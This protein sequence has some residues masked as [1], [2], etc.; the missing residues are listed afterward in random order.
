MTTQIKKRQIFE[1]EQDLLDFGRAYL[2]EAFPNP[3]RKG[4]PPEEMLR[5]LARRPTQSDPSITDH[6]T[7]CSPCFNAYMAHLDH[8][9]AEAKESSRMR[10]AVWFKWSAV[11][12]GIGVLFVIASYLLFMKP[13][14]TPS[15][16]QRPPAPVGKPGIPAQIP[17]TGKYIPVLVDLSTAA[18]GR[19]TND[20]RPVRAKQTVPANQFVDLSLHLPVGSDAAIYSIQIRSKRHTE[21]TDSGRA[22]LENGQP[23]LRMHADFSHIHPGKYDLLVVSKGLRLRVPINVENTPPNN[24]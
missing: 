12:A 3:E 15:I 9:R 22:R 7:C 4:C 14:N 10:R 1:R 2:S 23:V 6:V 16:T 11:F 20:G 24:R 8:A 5:V 21:W 17:L 19:G 18:P 13:Q